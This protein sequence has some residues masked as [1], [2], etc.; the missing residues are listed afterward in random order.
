MSQV[1]FTAAAKQVQALDGFAPENLLEPIGFAVRSSFPDGLTAADLVAVLTSEDAP[2]VQRALR[3]QLR[4]WDAEEAEDW[5]AGTAPRTPERRAR[6]YTL[7]GVPAEWHADLDAAYP[8]SAGSVVIAAPQPWD[9]WYTPGLRRERDFYWRAYTGVLAAKNWDPDVV[10]R[11][12]DATTEVVKRLA[13]PTRDEPY[14]SKGLVVGYVQSGKTANFSGVVAKAVDAGYRLVIVLT[15]TIEMLRSQT[16]RRLDMELVG[17]QNI[18]AGVADDYAD[19]EDWLADRFLVHD[20]D[21]NKTN[22]VPAIRRLTTSDFDYK[23][24]LA[25]LSALHFEFADHTLPLH[26]PTNLHGSNIRLAVVKKNKSTLEKLVADLKRIPTDLAQVPTLIIDDEADQASVNT[27]NPG[28]AKTSEDKDRTAINRM[29]AELLGM[30]PRAQYIGYT[31]TPFANVFVDPEDSQDIFPKDFIVSLER[32][33][34]YMG[35]ADFHDFDT[36][37]DDADGPAPGERTPAN[38]NELAYVRD[39]VAGWDEDREPE[40][41]RAVDS[42][43][44]AGAVKLFRSSRGAGPFRHHTMLVHESVKQAEHEVLAQEF[45]ALWRTG[46][47]S[48]AQGLA[49]LEALWH[50]DFA[51]VCAARAGRGDAIP[52]AFD[53][54]EPFVGAAVDKISEGATPV[55]VVNGAAEKDYGQD[56]LDFQS[57]GVWK[58]LVGGTKLSRGFTV[59]GLTTTYYT[60]RTLQADT[61]MQMGRWFGFRPGYRDL[62]RLFIGRNVNGP[63]GK[64]FDLYEAFEAIVRDEE[65][66]RAELARFSGLNED[67]YPMVRPEHVPPMV[68]QQ[69]PWLRPTSSNKMYNAELAYRGVGGESFSFTM[70]PPRK[71]DVN[72]RHFKAVR[73]LLEALDELGIFHF[74]DKDGRTRQF[75]ARYG[76]VTAEQLLTAVDQFVW[77]PNWDFTPHRE[78]L[79]RAMDA[80]TL[81]EWAVL[82]PQPKTRTPV[83]VEGWG[84]LPIVNR[85]RRER[86]YRRGFSGTAVRERDA[87]ESIAGNTDKDG[88]PLARQLHR[89]ARGGLLLMFASDPADRHLKRAA[90]GPIDPQDL[91]TLFSYALPRAAEPKGRVGFRV[92]KTGGAIVDA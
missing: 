41:T 7:L 87:I 71:A 39:L 59:E 62:V 76:V 16:Q 15:G 19:D 81:T 21:P 26:H 57:R 55:I 61:L 91:A 47:Y 86:D 88:G 25:G 82:L 35:G 48:S 27:V 85:Q 44:L 12:D 70:Q 4:R 5:A 34:P 51:V 72:P 69:L 49:R 90:T 24:L 2:L 74:A 28:K 1:V 77:D 32:P 29:I 13:D 14:Q 64:V 8:G 23:S 78:S 58:I 89:P 30:L 31:A 65:E 50:N 53:E 63:A 17:R 84:P 79:V 80:G 10:D 36:G 75:A 42:F 56:A 11:L 73:P 68:F 54:L 37:L 40:M 3:S 6:A 45:R 66:F 33:G 67:G 38:S 43:V 83:H 46:G 60:R 9:P 52:A 20:V 18:E 92:K 22:D